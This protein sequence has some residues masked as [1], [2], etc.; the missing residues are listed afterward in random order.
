MLKAGSA[1]SNFVPA[2]VP[3]WST[4]LEIHSLYLTESVGPGAEPSV[5]QAPSVEEQGPGVGESAKNNDLT[6]LTLG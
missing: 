1:F 5:V 3:L 2:F 4:S 6:L